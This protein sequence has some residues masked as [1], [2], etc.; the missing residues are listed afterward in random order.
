[1]K[2]TR[3]AEQV[4]EEPARNSDDQK[5]TPKIHTQDTDTLQGMNNTDFTRPRSPEI[6]SRPREAIP[7]IH[8]THENNTPNR[9]SHRSSR[10]TPSKKH[11]TCLF[12]FVFG[13][14]TG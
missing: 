9:N 1:M 8:D 12:F 5:F 13:N 11:K 3:S 6:H 2:N 7:E 14:Q 10:Q 4:R